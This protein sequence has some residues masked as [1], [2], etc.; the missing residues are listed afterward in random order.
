MTPLEARHRHALLAEEIRRHEHA[1]YV[2]SKPIISDFEFDR[3]DRELRDL[4]GRFPELVTPDSPS[5]RVGGLPV[6]EFHPVRHAVPMM[7]LD[8]SYSPGEVRAFIARVQKALADES[9]EWTVE[10]KVDGLSISL[11]YENGLFVQGATRGDGTTGDDVTANLRTVRSL[12]LRLIG[13]P[14]LLEVRGEVFLPLAGFRRLNA[15][16]ESAGE[17]PFANPRN[18]AAGSLKQLDPRIT[19]RRP[20][21]LVA[22]G[23]GMVEGTPLPSD[24]YSLLGWL[25]RLGLPVPERVMLARSED[26]VLIGIEE[27]DRVRRDFGYETDGA[28]VKLNSLPLRDRLGSTAKAPRW[29]MAYKY[30]PEQAET[31]L[32]SITVQVGRTGKLTPVAELEPVVLAGST[33]GRATLHNEDELR[34]KDIR[35]GDVVVIEKAGE[36]IP[37]VVRV[38]VGRRDGTESH[39]PFPHT[40]PE[41]QTPTVRDA[42]ASGEGADWRCP[43]PDC[44]AQLRG[45]IG[46]W[47]ARGAMDIEGAGDVLVAQLVGAGLVRDVA[48]LYR[49]RVDEVAALDRMGE[50]SARNLIDG[51]AASTHRDLWRLLFGLGI[52]H[53]GV[54]GAKALARAYPDLDALAAAGTAE[55]VQVP[56]IGEVIARSVA[57]WF[58]DDKN[59]DLIRRLRAA[60]VN[61]TS[62]LYRPVDAVPSGPF[63]GRTFVLT[64]TL[65]GMTRESATAEIES[66]GGKVSSSVSRKTDFVLA[67]EEAGSKLEKARQLGIPILD[68]A[69]FRRL[70]GS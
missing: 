30:P 67:G 20:L 35:I 18:A 63:A 17:E 45:R 42:T 8:N 46:H 59:R 25:Q 32:R 6:A 65:P 57:D 44:P 16:R 5:Q 58:S 22:Y 41:C 60:G 43:N 15:E 61:F 70:A 33:V 51:I 26:E 14:A 29:A 31:R 38:V 37:A 64:G 62:S 39:F 2:Q 47:C 23:T 24:Q 11:R 52:L 7:S 34:R 50:K 48:E 10:P 55:L 27:L 40:C 56:D 4:E 21:A 69:E 54:S 53:L 19:A 66:R 13:A 1:Y 9:L 36:V 68:E 3:L 12:P 28:V 49:L